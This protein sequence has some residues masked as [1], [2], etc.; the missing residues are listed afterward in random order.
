MA[1]TALRDVSKASVAAPANTL[2]Q[3]IDEAGH[4][5]EQRSALDKAYN[6][7]R[8]AIEGQMVMPE[9]GQS[10]RIDGSE[11]YANLQFHTQKQVKIKELFRKHPDIFW[12]LIEIPVK[13]LEDTL[14]PTESHKLVNVTY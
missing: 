10:N 14:G 3:L 9:V 5:R 4:I 12:A 2:A 11:F 8:V 1:K 7:L 6:R 13:A